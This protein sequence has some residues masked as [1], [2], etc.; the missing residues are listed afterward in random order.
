MELLLDYRYASSAREDIEM[1][2]S[3]GLDTEDNNE[4]FLE[5]IPELETNDNIP[6]LLPLNRS[7]EG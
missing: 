1:F 3:L 6:L 7:K 5:N 2:R 4:L